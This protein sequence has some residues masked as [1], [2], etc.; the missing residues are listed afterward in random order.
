MRAVCQRARWECTRGYAQ[1]FSRLLNRAPMLSMETQRHHEQPGAC[2]FAGEN[3]DVAPENP[4]IVARIQEK[5]LEIA[6]DLPRRI[7]R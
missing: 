2:P 1:R 6:Q 3:Y 7:A 5:I 4:R